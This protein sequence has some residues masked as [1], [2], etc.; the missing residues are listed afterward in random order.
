M[1]LV[2]LG[3]F[4]VGAGVGGVGGS[5]GGLEGMCSFV[6]GGESSGK[7]PILCVLAS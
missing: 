2:A 4:C 7:R 3:V 5:E 6:G 1:E